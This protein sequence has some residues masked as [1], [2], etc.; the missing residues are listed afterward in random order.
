MAGSKPKPL[1][2][3]QRRGTVEP[4]R[5]RKRAKPNRRVA[6]K[7][8]GSRDYVAIADGY[9]DDVLNGRIVAGQWVKKACARYRRMREGAESSRHNITTTFSASHVQDV[10]TFI[11]SLPHVEGRW[12]SANI[13]LQPWQVWILSACYGFRKSDGSRLVSTVF[14]EV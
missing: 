6:R 4:H 10:C 9:V 14:F 1:E 13:H 5:E 12:S 7:P 8:A 3:K 2:V 11:E